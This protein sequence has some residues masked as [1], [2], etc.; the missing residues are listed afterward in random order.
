MSTTE[1]HKT[2]L[3]QCIARNCTEHGYDA[4]RIPAADHPVSN[5]RESVGL[6]IDRIAENPHILF[7]CSTV[8]G[9][10]DL[11]ADD[12]VEFI[13]SALQRMERNNPY[14]RER[15]LLERCSA[16]SIVDFKSHWERLH[17]YLRR[18]HEPDKLDV[19]FFIDEFRAVS[20]AE[21]A[22]LR[23]E[24]LEDWDKALLQKEIAYELEILSQLR[25]RFEKR[26][27]EWIVR[28]YNVKNL[29]ASELRLFWGLNKGIWGQHTFQLLS[30]V[31]AV[32]DRNPSIKTLLDALGRKC[33]DKPV[34]KTSVEERNTKTHVVRF[35]AATKSDIDGIGL[36]NRLDAL[37]PVEVALLGHLALENMFYRKFTEHRLQTFDSR[38]DIRIRETTEMPDKTAEQ[39]GPYIVCV[40]TS[41]SMGGSPESV[42]KAICYELLCRARTEKRKCY[43]ITFSVDIEELDLSDIAH[44]CDDIIS[45]LTHSFHGGTDFTAALNRALELLD[46]ETFTL[47][48]VLFISD[49]D[50][51]EPSSDTIERM[52]QKQQLNVRFHALEIGYGG[53]REILDLFDIRWRYEHNKNWIVRDSTTRN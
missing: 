21:Y 41:A 9:M 17:P 15:D 36:S 12:I 40:D 37:L 47:A 27:S 14:A 53:H 45:F 43:L 16:F 6:T 39:T 32:C 29:S 35:H 7:G 10:A 42:A 2:Y 11:V 46:S 1:E 24:F 20:D 22:P 44:R 28:Y 25:I 3:L 48:D 34:P 31:K 52:R 23:R 13:E 18:R 19:D 8:V 33:N 50:V 26:I 5:I 4:S 38:S 49:F 51:R 30:A